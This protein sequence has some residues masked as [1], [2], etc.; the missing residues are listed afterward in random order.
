MMEA[1]DASA[2]HA[3]LSSGSAMT[4]IA[5]AASAM[6]EDE[7]SLQRDNSFSVSLSSTTINC[8]LFVRFDVGDINAAFINA[9]TSSCDNSSP[10]NLRM[11][12]RFL[13][14]SLKFSIPFFVSFN[15]YMQIYAHFVL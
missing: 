14:N 8:Q 12:L 10:V 15:L 7:C 1:T 4:T 9:T 2:I 11:L 13:I 6:K 3:S 5:N